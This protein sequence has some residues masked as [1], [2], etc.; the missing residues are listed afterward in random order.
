M[1]IYMNEA[2]ACMIASY[3]MASNA[4]R[5][6]AIEV[7][8]TMMRYEY[9]DKAPRLTEVKNIVEEA[10]QAPLWEDKETIII[11]WLNKYSNNEL[12]ARY[13]KLQKEM[14]EIKALME[15]E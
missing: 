12:Q 7:L 14:D 4:R 10:W 1:K 9:R 2:L 11:N 5:I 8:H 13:E 6:A 3:L 15:K